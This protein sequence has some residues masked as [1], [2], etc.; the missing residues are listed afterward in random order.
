MR[1]W[2]F[3]KQTY[4]NYSTRLFSGYI[5][6]GLQITSQTLTFYI[7]LDTI[8]ITRQTLIKLTGN[9]SGTLLLFSAFHLHIITKLGLKRS[10][11]DKSRGEFLVGL[12]NSILVVWFTIIN[13]IYTMIFDIILAV[14][15]SS[16]NRYDVNFCMSTGMCK[17]VHVSSIIDSIYHIILLLYH[18]FF[19]SNSQNHSKKWLDWINLH[20]DDVFLLTRWQTFA[21]S[22]LTQAPDRVKMSLLFLSHPWKNTDLH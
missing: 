7:S 8:F 10:L 18:S 4:K 22:Y 14:F 17:F 12:A 3:C 19:G 20:W 9:Y 16:N 21:S 13:W 11:L 2:K 1:Q 15:A 5:Q 6:S